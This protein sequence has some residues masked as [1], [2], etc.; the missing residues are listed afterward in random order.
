MNE[1][2]SYHQLWDLQKHSLQSLLSGITIVYYYEYS[3]I[4]IVVYYEKD[5]SQAWD[6]PESIWS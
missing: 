5:Y 4:L 6:G 1:D 2:D 3:I